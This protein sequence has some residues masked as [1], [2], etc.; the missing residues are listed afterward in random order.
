[1]LQRNS[2]DSLVK[3]NF[4]AT[5]QRAPFAR[6]AFAVL[7]VALLIGFWYVVMMITGN[8]LIAFC[9]SLLAVAG[10]LCGWKC[11]ANRWSVGACI[12]VGCIVV[13]RATELGAQ[14]QFL[15]QG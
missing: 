14:I 9:S 6:F 2:N 5:E 1:M 10:V 12:V 8:Q 3:E 7:S 4:S 15:F 13:S 11:S